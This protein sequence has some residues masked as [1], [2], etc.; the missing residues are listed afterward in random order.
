MSERRDARMDFLR[1]AGWGA[2]EVQALAGDA[3]TRR[4][5]RVA[6]DGRRAM[7]M[8]QPQQAETPAAPANATAEERHALGY[9]AVARLAGADCARFVAV[10]EF[11]QDRGLSTPEIHAVDCNAGFVL[12]EDFGDRLYADIL[13]GGGNERD[14]YKA[15]V[16]ALAHLHANAA[17]A[18]ISLQVPLHSYDETAQLAEA[19]LLTDWY[20]PLALNRKA[21]AEETAEHRALWRDLLASLQDGDP[22]FV[23]R[24]YHAQ[25]LLWLPERAGVARV[26][27]IDFQDAVA[28]SRAYDLVS[29]LEDARRDVSPELAE[30]MV[31]HYIA[32]MRAQGSV[33][34]EAQLRAALAIMAAQR[35]A[36]IAGIFARLQ[37]RD[38]K[39]R[40]L[41]YLP[42]VWGYLAHDLEH[43][44]L[45]PLKG[46]YERVL[47]RAARE[48]RIEGVAA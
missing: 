38:G 25:N 11:L 8:D 20:L 9:N 3:S 18:R 32:A 34:D 27:L 40:Y 6:S 37:L 29:L 26:G 30:A 39:P 5:F 33:V 12:M 2:A 15:A 47:P 22:A 10:A 35:N 13:S 17:P 31:A 4:Y 14:L 24:D 23:H 44:A 42:R 16:E 46:W 45:A 43:P 36:K 7:L 21:T 48:G 1:N 41:D 19:A 28:G